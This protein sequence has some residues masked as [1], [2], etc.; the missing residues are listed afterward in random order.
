MIFEQFNVGQM[1]NYCYLFADD[2]TKE[3]FIVDP[4][5]EPEKIQQRIKKH[6]VNLTKIFLTHHHFDH[7]NAADSVKTG[8]GARIICHKDSVLHLQ[9]EASHDDL[10]DDNDI[11]K[12]GEISVRCI[13][14]PGHAPG[15]IC[16][17]VNEKYLI[18]G[19]T[20]F[21]GNCGRADLPGS[22]PE[23]LFNSLQKIK[24]LD[25]NLIVCPGHHYGSTPMRTLAEEIKLNPTLK[26]S[27][28]SEFIGV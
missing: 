5:F 20:L 7:V 4:S 17:I 14:T 22:N 18:T 28:Y 12:I 13:H 25:G 9:G 15:S 23:E 6:G 27:N 3:G 11:L 24:E 26:A 10:I 2:S 16:L 1:Y 21:I 19:D 8:T